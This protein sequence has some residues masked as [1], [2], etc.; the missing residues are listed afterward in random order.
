MFVVEYVIDAD[1]SIPLYLTDCEP[2]SEA[3]LEPLNPLVGDQ[4]LVT[5]LDTGIAGQLEWTGQTW[6][7]LSL[8]DPD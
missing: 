5:D 8:I 6:T 4:V 3:V 1:T 7:I 2:R